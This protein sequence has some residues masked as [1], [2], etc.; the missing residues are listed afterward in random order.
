MTKFHL[1]ENDLLPF[2][3]FKERISR[4][5]LAKMR[6]DIVLKHRGKT[7]STSSRLKKSANTN[8]IA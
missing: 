2:P 6:R 1:K 3:E 8:L 7:A 4:T 5:S